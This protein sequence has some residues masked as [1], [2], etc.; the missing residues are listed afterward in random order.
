MF[1]RELQKKEDY[2][3]YE[4]AAVCR[5][6]RR[7]ALV[8][9]L[10]VLLLLTFASPQCAAARV[11]LADVRPHAAARGLTPPH[12]EGG[13]KQQ[14]LSVSV[15]AAGVRGSPAATGNAARVLG[16]VPSPGVGH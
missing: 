2:Y 9:V 13:D 12:L 16:S 3:C 7:V 14:G 10:L 8:L 11:L 15:A 1:V 5:C 6:G 4:M